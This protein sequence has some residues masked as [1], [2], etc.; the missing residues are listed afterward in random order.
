ML[1]LNLYGVSLLYVSL[2]ESCLSSA[3]FMYLSRSIMASP[4]FL[5]QGVMMRS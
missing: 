1:N 3:I 5:L 4:K 2:S